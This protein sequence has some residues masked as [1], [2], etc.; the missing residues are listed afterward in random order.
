M[1]TRFTA[2][3]IFLVALVVA[4]LLAQAK[5]DSNPAIKTD[6]NNPVMVRIPGKNYEIG[7]Y[8]VTQAEWRAVMG[9]NPSEF[10]NCGD[11]C[12]VE[13]V[14]WNDAQEFIQKLNAKTGK[15]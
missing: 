4:P 15:Q 14:S 10:K 2:L 5:D 12:P 7:K 9:N 13:N 6:G 1:I 3:G 11:N 8:E